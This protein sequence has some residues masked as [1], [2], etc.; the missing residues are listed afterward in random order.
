MSTSTA[1]G[2]ATGGAPG[3]A[4]AA[5]AAVAVDVVVLNQ[6]TRPEETGRCL[7]SVRAQTGVAPRVVV[8]GNGW[9]PS[10]FADDIETVH[11]EENVGI[12]AG[13]NHGAREGTADLVFFLDDDAWLPDRDMLARVAAIFAAHPHLGALQPRIAD[14]DGTTLRRW[15]PRAH[16]GDP[17]RAGPAFT[18][19]E[20]VT[21]V[22]RR[23]FED[24]GGFPGRFFYG[25]E[26][27]ELA[28]RMRDRGWSLWYEPSLVVHHPATETTRHAAFFRMN[29]RNRA[30]VARRNLPLPL[31]VVYLCTW[32]GIMAVRT[33]RR[34]DH[35]RVWVLG[36]LEGLRTDA[37][38]RRPLRWR[39]VLRMA[40]LG[41]PPVI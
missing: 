17:H 37:G 1:D 20:G 22:R 36:L 23:A 15:V 9:R 28:W 19:A 34:P 33:A 35:L 39:T 6:G 26:G 12:P 30:W 38:R 18:A 10:G 27:I 29:A 4:D 8:V 5:Q 40:R 11:L 41:Q 24:V 31:A 25:H 2:T 16:V 13:R 32:T 14:P 3:S 21:I 7:D